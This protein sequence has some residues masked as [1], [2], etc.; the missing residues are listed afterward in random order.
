ME[1]SYKNR[2]SDYKS[3]ESASILQ[4]DAYF[5]GHSSKSIWGM[6]DPDIYQFINL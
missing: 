1:F 6:H 3:C 2:T 5:T 4:A